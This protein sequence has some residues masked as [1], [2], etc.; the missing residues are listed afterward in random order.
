MLNATRIVRNVFGSQ[1]SFHSLVS[2]ADVQAGIGG[3]YDRL[4][5]KHFILLFLVSTSAPC[6]CIN[7]PIGSIVQVNCRMDDNLIN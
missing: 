3:L 1:P 2:S 7:K 5:T 4:E 6:F